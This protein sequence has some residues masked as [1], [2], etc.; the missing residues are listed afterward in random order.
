MCPCFCWNVKETTKATVVVRIVGG[1]KGLCRRPFLGL[2]KADLR[3]KDG[4]GR[5]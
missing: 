3:G 4:E 1:L 5:G 2:C